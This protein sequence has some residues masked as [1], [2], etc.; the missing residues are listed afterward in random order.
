MIKHQFANHILQV[1]T[2]TI[3]KGKSQLDPTDVIHEVRVASNRIRVEKVIGYVKGFT[4]LKVDIPSSKV[5]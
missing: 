2:P 4:F 5:P 3:L 1:N